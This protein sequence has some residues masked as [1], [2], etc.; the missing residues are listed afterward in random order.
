MQKRRVF[1]LWILTAVVGMLPLP[2]G[3]GASPARPA[4]PIG[5][6]GT[7][8]PAPAAASGTTCWQKRAYYQARNPG[9]KETLGSGTRF[10]APCVLAA[11]LAIEQAVAEFG[12]TRSL[13]ALIRVAACESLLQ[14]TMVGIKDP[15]DVGLFQWNDKPPRYWWSS[16]RR[17]F[18]AWQ[19]RKAARSRG[20]YVARHATADR[21]DPY[22][23]ARVAAWVVL[24]YPR[25]WS[26]AWL[27]KGVYDPAI[28]RIR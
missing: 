17:A 19:D 1:S 26:V 24:V 18:D 6:S 25:S 13:D 11:Y 28:G 4:G 12:V 10:S 23:A 3:A 14:P 21:K 7:S 9:L 20:V 5:P 16:A 8:A 27:C 15:N 22:N 2:V